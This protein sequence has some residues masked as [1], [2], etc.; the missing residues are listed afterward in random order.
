MPCLA[1]M[2][3]CENHVEI[4][5]NSSKDSFVKKESVRFITRSFIYRTVFRCFHPRR[6]NCLKRYFTIDQRIARHFVASL[7]VFNNPLPFYAT[8]II[9][10]FLT[11]MIL[12]NHD[13]GFGFYCILVLFFIV[14]L[15]IRNFSL[16]MVYFYLCVEW[17]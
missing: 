15:Y 8:Q 5:T 1:T 11:S 13:K 2:R 7:N 16:T 10:P 14:Q 17:P 9:G 12:A 6:S 4:C 3:R